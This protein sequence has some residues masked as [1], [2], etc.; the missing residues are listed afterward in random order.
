MSVI[1]LSLIVYF[2][3]LKVKPKKVKN[4][5]VIFNV[6]SLNLLNPIDEEI[7]EKIEIFEEED[8]LEEVKLELV[9]DINYDNIDN[10]NQYIIE[11]KEFLSSYGIVID[12]KYL[13][14]F[15][16]AISSGRLII[17]N[18]ENQKMKD[19]FLEAFAIFFGA[20]YIN[21]FYNTLEV[22]DSVNKNKDLLN[23]INVSNEDYKNSTLKELFNC[24]KYPN[25][26]CEVSYYDTNITTTS[27]IWL[28]LND[29]N[30][31]IEELNS[32]IKVDIEFEYKEQE[33]VIETKGEKV[34]YFYFNEIV[35]GIKDKLYLDEDDWK[36]I[37][38]LNVHISK[39]H[40]G[41]F[42]NN[43][44]IQSEKYTSL[45]LYFEYLKEDV[46]DSLLVNKFL[47]IINLINIVKKD[48]EEEGL[49]SVCDRLFGLE[50]LTRSNY[51]LTR[52]R[53]NTKLI[54]D[55]ND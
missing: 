45:L 20:N 19:D 2:I 53:D 14:K 31:N 40:K 16:A 27:N 7:Y 24:L 52:I 54:G 30:Y 39:F 38:E 33:E 5:P 11:F 29:D 41:I 32:L 6:D 55:I 44:L 13:H 42:N 9:E 48:D 49:H 15:I 47:P 1:N 26:S 18:T 43:S 8:E 12:I 23:I 50:N 36:K 34:S 25:G 22:F 51:L 3:K 46:I 10:F 21:N 35:D 37:D 4:K 28:F 17:L